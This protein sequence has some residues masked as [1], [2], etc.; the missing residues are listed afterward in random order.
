MSTEETQKKS[1]RL[2]KVKAPLSE[3]RE[4]A[5]LTLDEFAALFGKKKNWA[6]RAVWT[7]KVKVIKPLGEM[8]IPRSEV[9][10]LTSAPL[11]Y[12]AANA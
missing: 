6:Y 5:A 2:P 12:D 8:L 3:L 11:D 4:R 9:E 1:K 7:G 10:R